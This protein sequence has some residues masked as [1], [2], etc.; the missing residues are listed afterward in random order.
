MTT[1]HIRVFDCDSHVLEPTDIWTKYLDAD[2]RISARSAFWHEVDDLGGPLTILNG[3]QAKEM[4]P[5]PL[6][7]QAIWRPGMK[8]EDIGALD[9]TVRHPITPGAQDPT[10][11]LKDMDAMGIDQALLFPTLFAEYFPIVENPDAAFALARAYNDWIA[12]FCSAAPRRLVPAAVLPLQD[13]SFAIRELQRVANKGFR[14]AF[15]RPAFVNQRF[16]NH[17]YYAPLWKQLED[18]GVAACIHPSTGNT[19]PEWTSQGS[20]VE[21]VASHLRIGHYVAESVAPMMDNAM[22]LNAICF[23]G[24][25]EEYPQLKLSFLHSSASWVP[26][27]LEK[28]E[29]YLWLMSSTQDVSL[30]PENVFFERPYLVGFNSWESSVARL[31]DIFKDVAAWGS[32]YPHHDASDVAEARGMLQQWKVPEDVAANYL[33]GNAA[34]HYGIQ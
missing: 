17:A 34:R 23:Y 15:I 21:R 14:A 3:K 8:P 1:N 7:R 28:A 13:V 31:T 32:R 18:L 4:N 11:R 26:L 2:Y 30:E 16:P 29:T 22:F 5:G 27:A 19:N 33:G 6:N 24:L 10:A 25:M 12:D 20:Y 9:P